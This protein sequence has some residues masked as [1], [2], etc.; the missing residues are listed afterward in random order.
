ML[1][2]KNLLFLA[3]GRGSN[4]QA[5]VDQT[6]L[7][8]LQNV[9]ISALICNRKGAMVLERARAAKVP[10][11][12]IEGVTA[13]KYSSSTERDEARIMFDKKCLDVLK[14]YSIDFVVLA[15]FDQIVSR[16]FVDACPFKIVNVHPAYDLKSFGGK[17]MMGSRVHE[18]VLKSGADYSGCTVHFV[19]GDVDQGPVIL[20]RRVEVLPSDTALTLEERVLSEEHL[21]YPEA[22]QLLVDARVVVSGPGKGC[23]VDLF[24]DDWDIKW[25]ERQSVY[26]KSRQ[27]PRE[28]V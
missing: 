1:L 23:F 20:K 19:T 9:A 25:F 18:S 3:S 8:V 22:V 7:G 17:G 12:E 15:G 21:V 27:G 26:S 2:A 14:T 6:R 10:A 16:A 11:I 5:F 13:K 4:F 24:S 28:A